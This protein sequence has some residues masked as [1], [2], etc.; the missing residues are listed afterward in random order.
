MKP[1]TIYSPQWGTLRISIAMIGTVAN[2]TSSLQSR[3]GSETTFLLWIQKR[4]C[5]DK[6]AF[7]VAFAS[8]PP[9]IEKRLTG[10]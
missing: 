6:F 4:K 9:T 8:M 7:K 2:G 10:K 5:D 1:I 3:L